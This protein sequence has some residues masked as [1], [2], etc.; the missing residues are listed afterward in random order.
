MFPALFVGHGSPTNASESNVYTSGWRALG[1]SLPRPRAI[2]AIS[3]HWFTRGTFVTANV[4]PPTIHD[5]GGFQPELYEVSYP[6]PGSPELAAALVSLLAPFK[7]TAASDWGLDHGTWSVL[8]HTDPRADIPI[9]QLSI[10]GTHPPQFHY[11]LGQTLATLRREGIL[12]F[13]SGGIVHN[14]GRLARSGPAATPAWAQEFDDWVRA[15]VASGDHAALVD[16]VS[17][18][19]SARLSVPTPEHYLPL[20]YVLGAQQPHERVTVPVSGFDLGSLSMTSF[21]VGAA[22]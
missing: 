9:V 15:C 22:G 10:D 8:V 14:L 1:S 5:F 20:L 11:A 21:V 7:V 12:V 17:R 19:Q 18:G 13:G 2:L 6:A 16:Y 3:A 4:T